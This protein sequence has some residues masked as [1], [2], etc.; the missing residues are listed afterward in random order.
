MELG[1]SLQEVAKRELYEECNLTANQLT[2]FIIFSGEEFY[3]QYPHGDEIY[4]VIATFVCKDYEGELRADKVEVLSL[5]F[6]SIDDL[7]S[8]LNPPE[9]PIIHEYINLGG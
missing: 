6:F 2:F 7:P 4:N 3:Y 8:H 9:I 5:Q 1:E